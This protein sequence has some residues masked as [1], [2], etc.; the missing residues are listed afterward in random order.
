VGVV[1]SFG[2]LHR[3]LGTT[4][5]TV[6]GGGSLN[7]NTRHNQHYRIHLKFLLVRKFWRTRRKRGSRSRYPNNECSRRS[8]AIA[9]EVERNSSNCENVKNLLSLSWRISSFDSRLFNAE[10][11]IKVIIQWL[12]LI[13]IERQNDNYRLLYVVTSYKFFYEMIFLVRT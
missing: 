3:V 8:L 9:Q 5:M 10:I 2:H 12:F 1:S 11:F 4:R 6:I 13:L 7:L